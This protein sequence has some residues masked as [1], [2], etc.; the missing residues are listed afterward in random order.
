MPITKSSFKPAWGLSNPH[1][2]TLWATIFRS[3]PEINLSSD[4]LELAD[5]DFLDIVTTDLKDKP[6]VIILHGLEGSLSSP[7]VKPL[8]KQLDDADYGVCFVHFRGCS[9]ELNRLPRSYHSG[10][11]HDL[12]SVVEYIQNVHK[13]EIFAVIGF[14]LGGNVVLKWLGEHGEHAP[15]KAGIAVSVPFQLED[16]GDPFRKKFFTCISKTSTHDLSK[17]VPT[18]V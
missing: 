15:V 14:S 1:L 12:G 10:D 11:T 4:R 5:G 2:Q 7:Y 17:K 13:Q 9:D 3:V 6:I 16:A 8:I 18:K